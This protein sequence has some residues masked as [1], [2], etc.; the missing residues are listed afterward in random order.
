MSSAKRRMRGGGHK[1][2][3]GRLPL[4]IRIQVFTVQIMVYG[5]GI[6]CSEGL[7]S[8]LRGDVQKLPTCCPAK[9]SVDDSV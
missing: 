3:Y 9:L 2:K 1:P 8:L 7:W 4:N 6:S 5:P